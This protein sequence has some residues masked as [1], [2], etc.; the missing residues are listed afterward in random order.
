ME[1]KKLKQQLQHI[2]MYKNPSEK[3]Y[4]YAYK[5]LDS[6]KDNSDTK[7]FYY[8]NM[9]KILLKQGRFD[10]AKYY[11]LEQLYN[12]PDNVAIFYHFYKISVHEKNYIDAY[13][14][15]MIIK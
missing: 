9:S 12:C 1:T 4:Q 3:Q 13:L 14:D 7:D 6:I 8:Y 5:V 15:L 2:F 11:L 10:E